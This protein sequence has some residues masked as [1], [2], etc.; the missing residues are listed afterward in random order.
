MCVGGSADWKKSLPDIMDIIVCCIFKLLQ[1]LQVSKERRCQSI[2]YIEICMAVR[3]WSEV[4]HSFVQ[5][6]KLIC[7][8]VFKLLQSG[9]FC[10]K[11]ICQPVK[12][13][14]ICMGMSFLCNRCDLTLND[15]RD[16]RGFWVLRHI[17]RY[18]VLALQTF[19]PLLFG[20]DIAVLHSD[21]IGTFAVKT[22]LCVFNT[23]KKLRIQVR[24]RRDRRFITLKA[25]FTDIQCDRNSCCSHSRIRFRIISEYC[26]FHRTRV[27]LRRQIQSRSLCAEHNGIHLITL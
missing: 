2:Q 19:Q 10:H 11:S 16:L 3:A 25:G 1:A 23:F 4:L 15:S 24:G 8:A 6:L 7:R 13:G 14:F 21:L 5:R 22:V 20:A 17:W 12:Y 27:K 9:E 18:A 26:H